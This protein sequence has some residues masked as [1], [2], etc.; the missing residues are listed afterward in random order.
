MN[1]DASFLPRKFIHI[2]ERKAIDRAVVG[3]T[4][5]IDQITMAVEGQVPTGD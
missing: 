1:K 5:P 4:F 2:F 3:K